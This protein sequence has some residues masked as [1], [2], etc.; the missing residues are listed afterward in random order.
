VTLLALRMAMRPEQANVD[1]TNEFASTHPGNWTSF[2]TE[3]SSYAHISYQ[4][5][6]T[7]ATAGID[8]IPLHGL[9]DANL[10]AGAV[11]MVFQW[12]ELVTEMGTCVNI[13]H[14]LCV[15]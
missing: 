15:Y 3:H 7:I 1:K 4:S 9:G 6:A 8:A 5:I 12:H 13:T 14:H 2:P 11:P 10:C